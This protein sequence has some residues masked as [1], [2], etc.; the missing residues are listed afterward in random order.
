MDIFIFEQD[1]FCSRNL[2]IA[3]L[4]D[5]RPNIRRLKPVATL[6]FVPEDAPVKTVN[7]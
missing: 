7:M 2:Q 4:K 5:R 1:G 3:C 6:F